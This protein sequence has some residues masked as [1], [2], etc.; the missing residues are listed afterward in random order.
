MTHAIP[1]E[2]VTGLKELS[3]KVHEQ[4]SIL[5]FV[6]SAYSV[7]AVSEELHKGVSNA[8]LIE[9]KL[10]LEKMLLLVNSSLEYKKTE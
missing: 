9:M 3:E 1:H 6:N 5:N 10:N 7:K 4:A 2:N 8:S